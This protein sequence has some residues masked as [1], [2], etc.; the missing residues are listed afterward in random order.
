MGT[1][2]TCKPLKKI[3][4]NFM[5]KDKN[6]AMRGFYS[7][8]FFNSESSFLFCSGRRIQNLR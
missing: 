7:I 2:Q 5:I 4:R 6:H 8:N 3:D 1:V